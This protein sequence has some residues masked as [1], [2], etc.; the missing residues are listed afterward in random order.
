[1]APR[2][3]TAEVEPDFQGEEWDIARDA[4][5]AQGNTEDE[6]IA[7]LQKSWRDQHQ[8]RLVA[9]DEHLQ[10]LLQDQGNQGQ[11]APMPVD[12][13]ETPAPEDER[14]DWTGRPT[15]SFLDIRPAHHVLKKL[16][17]KEYVDLWH[18]TAQGCREAASLDLATPDDTFSLVSTGNG[19]MLQSV[20]AAAVQSSKIVKDENLSFEQWSE[21]KTRLLSC[22]GEHG[23]KEDETNELAK[24]FLNL[25]FHPMRSERF[26]LQAV[27]RYQERVRR[28]WTGAL[29]NNRGYTIGTINKDLLVDYHRQILSEVQAQNNVST[30]VGQGDETEH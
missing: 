19:L 24:F 18:F 3:P 28:H 8:R 2:D 12:P 16:E 17:K 9:W 23:W 1:M 29:R 20:G 21:G 25:D 13:A 11:A 6:A 14:P 26:G 5:V 4:L 27:L 22:M 30:S 15:P 7:V 10:Q